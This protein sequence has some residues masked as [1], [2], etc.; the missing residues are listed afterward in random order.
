MTT[1]SN[2]TKIMNN[3]IT[4]N[5]NQKIDDA[6]MDDSGEFYFTTF[7]FRFDGD[8]E[9]CGEEWR[10]GYIKWDTTAEWK[11]EAEAMEEHYRKAMEDW[12]SYE[13]KKVC[14][15][16]ESVACD[17]DVFAVEDDNGNSVEPEALAQLIELM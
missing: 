3:D 13:Y 10:E 9:I 5:K 8:E 2:E 4:I 6:R 14:L 15:D 12:G 11:E 16:D 7:E 1:P 17:W